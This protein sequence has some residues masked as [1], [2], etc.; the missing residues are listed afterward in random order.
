VHL[1][2]QDAG[3]IGRRTGIK[4][5]LGKT[6]RLYLKNKAK[7]EMGAWFHSRK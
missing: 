5:S 6:M 4:A 7:K 3:G 2:S 1:S